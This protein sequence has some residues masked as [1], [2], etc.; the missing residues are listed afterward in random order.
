MKVSQ[1]KLQSDKKR[2][3]KHPSNQL[4]VTINVMNP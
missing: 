2:L 4:K 1:V 3:D